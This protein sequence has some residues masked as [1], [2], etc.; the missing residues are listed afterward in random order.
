M[1]ARDAAG[2]PE[3]ARLRC[4]LWILILGHVGC[5]QTA[6][7]ET[8]LPLCSALLVSALFLSSRRQ[9]LEVTLRRRQLF[10]GAAASVF[11]AV[12]GKL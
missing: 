7:W 3:R 11:K 6:A 1:D 9:G 2:G 12:G 10:G 8:A 4:S 5:M